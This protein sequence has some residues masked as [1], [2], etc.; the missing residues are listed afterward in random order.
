ML[1][2]TREYLPW[3]TSE[4]CLENTG[5]NGLG[6]MSHAKRGKCAKVTLFRLPSLLWLSSTVVHSQHTIE[7]R[8]FSQTIPI[9]ALKNCRGHPPDF[10]E[11]VCVWGGHVLTISP[12][13]TPMVHGNRRQEYS[14]KDR[15]HWFS[16]KHAD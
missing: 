15:T 4:T 3:L 7:N 8:Q 10:L 6:N 5:L 2:Q 9:S 11:C 14:F 12:V 1:K 16:R 13:A